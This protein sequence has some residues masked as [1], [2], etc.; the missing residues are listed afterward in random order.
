MDKPRWIW[1]TGSYKKLL[2]SRLGKQ[3][4]GVD[5]KQRIGGNE[6]TVN[7]CE[8]E[9]IGILPKCTI[10]SGKWRKGSRIAR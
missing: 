7:V 5:R 10:L 1:G 8:L 4:F 9:S 6:E 3:L 2:L